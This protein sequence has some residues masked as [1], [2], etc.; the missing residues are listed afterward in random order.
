MEVISGTDR[1][2]DIRKKRQRYLEAGILLWE[3][4][5][6]E[7][8]IDVYA[9]GQPLATYGVGSTIPVEVIKDL[10]VEVAKLFR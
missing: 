5:P 4:Y 6:D 8:V 3:L 10:R 9:P 2:L 7:H 1:P